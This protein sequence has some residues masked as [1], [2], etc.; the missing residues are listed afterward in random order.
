MPGLGIISQWTNDEDDDLARSQIR[1]L[2]SLIESAAEARGLLIG[3]R[4]MNDA[5]QLQS[6]FQKYSTESLD[7]LTG[8]SQ[9]WDPEDV[10]QNLQNAGFL[11]PKGATV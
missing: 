2:I 8:V 3:F 11:L 6:P 9:K 4:F 5:S 7:F 10:F 1:Q